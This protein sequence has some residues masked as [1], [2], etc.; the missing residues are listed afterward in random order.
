[1]IS[2]QPQLVLISEPRSQFARTPAL[3]VVN[4][5]PN[6]LRPFEPQTSV[7]TK[8][9]ASP[10]MDNESPSTLK[11]VGP[12]TLQNTSEPMLERYE[13]VAGFS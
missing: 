5:S 3:K 11:S 4:K 8:M 13:G 7:G 12:Q 6:I 2:S 9:D 1:M 10:V